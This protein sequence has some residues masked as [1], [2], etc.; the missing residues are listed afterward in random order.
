[1][2]NKLDVKI[3][4]CTRAFYDINKTLTNPSKLKYKINKYLFYIQ[5]LKLMKIWLC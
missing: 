4:E 2:E 5:L 1:M 3:N